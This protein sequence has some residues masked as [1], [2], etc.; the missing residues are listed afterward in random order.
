MEL[1]TKYLKICFFESAPPFGDRLGGI[2]SY[3]LHR[4]HILSANGFE[5][6]WTDGLRVALFNI[7]KKEWEIVKEFKTDKFYRIKKRYPH[8][9]PGIKYLLNEIKID[10][11]EFLDSYGYDI[12]KLKGKCKVIIQCHTS[13]PVRDFLNYL[14]LS[15]R[16]RLNAKRIKKNSLNAD[17]ILACSFEIATLTSGFYK[18]HLDKF[19]IIHHAFD[20]ELFNASE[21]INNTRENYFIAVANVEYIKGI[22]LIL[23][24][25]IEYKNKGGKNQLFYI[26][27]KDL[28]DVPAPMKERWIE[29]GTNK[30]IE[31]ID[32]KYFKFIPYVSKKE[33]LN[34]MSRATATIILSRFE[35]FTMVVGEAASV[36][37]P[38]IVSNRLGWNNLINRFDA[39]I[40][41][42]PYNKDEVVN[43]MLK[44]EDNNISNI[45]S[46]NI[47][48][49]FNYL[50]S[51]L[52]IK[53]TVD[54]YQFV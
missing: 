17:K 3:I 14:P 22:D 30:L 2:A 50:C 18:V 42:N 52:L 7:N 1:K 23:K 36:G 54:E 51:D 27:P 43:A 49:L 9:S 29:L 26:G 24:A 11:I 34:L 45:Y 38:I 12:S 48:K 53:N 20:K 32:S 5:V 16:A 35:A 31:Q 6:Y 28:F 44:M 41:I 10:I 40:M 4:A 15:F 46:D 25:F 8:L 19:N 13:S 21:I 39:G 37:C 33:L 47:S